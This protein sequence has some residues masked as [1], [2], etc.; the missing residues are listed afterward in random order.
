MQPHQARPNSNRM[1]GAVRCICAKTLVSEGFFS[2]D[3]S[4]VLKCRYANVFNKHPNG[5]AAAARRHEV[6]TSQSRAGCVNHSFLEVVSRCHLAII[7]HTARALT[8]GT[9]ALLFHLDARMTMRWRRHPFEP[10]LRPRIR[11]SLLFT[12]LQCDVRTNKPTT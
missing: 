6:H 11:C 5:I 10:I 1:H 9:R 12:R 2:S 8:Y 7:S 4:T 3:L